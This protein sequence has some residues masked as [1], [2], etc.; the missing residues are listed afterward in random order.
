MLPRYLYHATAVCN[1]ESIEQEGLRA[2]FEGV[3]ASESE[4][5]C[6]AFMGFRL[7]S[8]FHFGKKG[9]DPVFVKHDKLVVFQIDTE[10]TDKSKWTE[11]TDHSPAFFGNATSRVYVGSIPREALVRVIEFAPREEVVA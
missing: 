4:D 5:D 8:H 1:Q 6:L 7:M 9:E 3:Y 11:G 10:A 2:G